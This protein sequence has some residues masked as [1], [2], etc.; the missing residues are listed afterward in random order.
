MKVLSIFDLIVSAFA[1]SIGI[2]SFSLNSLESLPT[3]LLFTLALVFL[4]LFFIA[5]RKYNKIDWK[6][7]VFF[8]LAILFSIVHIMLPEYLYGFNINGI[9]HRS[10]SSAIFLVSL[11]LP[12]TVYSLY[13]FLGAKP[14]SF[15]ISR[16]PILILP[17]VI[18]LTLYGL[19]IYKVI[20]QGAPQLDWKILTTPFE[21]Q[22][23]KEMVWENGWPVWISH[24]IS[25]AGIR[26]HILGTF[27]LIGITSL[28]SLPIGVGVGVYVSEFSVGTLTNLIK[29]STQMLR[30]I[31][32]FIIAI[33]AY[34]LVMHA[35]GSVF[36]DFISGYFYDQNGA[37]HLATGSFITASIFLSFLVIPIIARA[38]E[39]GI[40]SLPNEIK[41]GSSAL[42]A[43]QSYTLGHI[44]LPWAMPNII[45]ALIL[46]CAETAGGLSIIMFMAGTGE[47]GLNPL[48]GVTSLAYLIFDIHYGSAFGNQ[49]PKLVGSYQFAAAFLL[50]LI[51]L[52]LT[53][54]ALILKRNLSRRYKG[55]S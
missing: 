27:L 14:K 11:G 26:N 1:L 8:L 25:Q 32:V 34:S 22:N 36:S 6:F 43:S 47:H 2:L 23:W 24:S 15:D 13:Y 49:V 40:R 10:F 7:L 20:V 30:A 46:G 21:F 51:T 9:I 28:I 39:D 42:G 31:S 50:L 17:I 19:L 3:I 37:K 16:Y 38:T 12:A 4:I 54:T 52:G 5:R 44:L 33:T 18:I 48:N 29:I 41:E 53:I 55:A 35:N 45:T